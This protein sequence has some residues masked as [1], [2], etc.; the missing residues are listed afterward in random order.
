MACLLFC[1]ASGCDAPSAL[2]PGTCG[3]GFVNQSAGEE[4]DDQGISAACDGDCTLAVCGDGIANELAGEECDTKV[5]STWCD[6]DCTV[7]RCGDGILNTAAG[8]ACDASGMDTT[9]CDRDCTTVACGDG[10]VN[11]AA[12]E[13][14]DTAGESALCDA[15]CTAASCG[16]AVINAVAGEEC[17]DGNRVDDDGCSRACLVQRDC[18]N[19][20]LDPAGAGM[21]PASCEMPGDGCDGAPSCD[22]TPLWS[23]HMGGL[24]DEAGQGIAVDSA[25][26]VLLSGYFNGTTDFGGGL[27]SSTGAYDVFAV[28]LDPQG[29]HLWSRRLGGPNHEEGWH[30][31]VDSAGNVLLSGYVDDT[32]DLG[33][34]PLPGPG[35]DVFVVKLD[36]QGQH[37]W[38]RRL[39]GPSED[40]VSG[41]AADSAGNVLLTGVFYRTADFGG[42]PISS[43]GSIDVFAVKL[44]AQGQHLWSRRLGG[45][46]ADEGGGI[47][48]DSAGNV[49]LTGSFQGMA[50]FGGGPL[51]SAGGTDVFAVKLDPQGQHLWSRRLGGTNVDYGWAI[52]V[53]NAGNVLL[54]GAFLGTA[55]FGGGPFS[56]VGSYDVFVVKLDAQG[57]HLWSQRLGGTSYDGAQAIAVDSSGN[58]LLT[59]SFQGMADF[60]GAPLSSEGDHDVF[61]VKLDAQGWHL[62]SQRF[63]G[64][65][66]DYCYAAAADSAGNGLLTGH[67]HGTADFGDGPVSSAGSYDIFAV[68]IRP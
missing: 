63:G 46:G 62:W 58:V 35:A 43:V 21:A 25:G 49:L 22:G 59:G 9:A 34:G 65:S 26:N 4:C 36:P 40:I 48:V 8:E 57:Q 10:S 68:K 3:D 16:D 15:D 6:E 38:S 44:D 47:A 24:G 13:Q 67:F 33:G 14:C 50:D 2:D 53:D 23:R 29:R 42:G 31:A 61:A 5:S 55:D 39:G 41:I 51:S 66:F 18:D 52:A 32:T 56:S 19:G 11:A 7:A 17:D 45:A 12:G 54:T 64:T 20:A 60:G 30:I 1:I 27:L 37:L 28:K